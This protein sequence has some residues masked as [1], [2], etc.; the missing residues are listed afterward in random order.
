VEPAAVGSAARAF[1]DLRHHRSYAVG[2]V[3]G[4]PVT[5][6]EFRLSAGAR[7]LGGEL[8]TPPTWTFREGTQW[9]PIYPNER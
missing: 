3:A 4:L 5:V 9:F 1:D 2:D 8:D 7:I 6:E